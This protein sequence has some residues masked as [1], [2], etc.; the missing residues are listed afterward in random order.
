M[1]KMEEN[2]RF[3]GRVEIPFKKSEDE[4]WSALQTRLQE[5]KSPEI[6]P[7]KRNYSYWFAA[8][9][10][11]V[12]ALGLYMFNGMANEVNVV[13]ESAEIKAIVLPDGSE[14]T[15][16]ADGKIKYHE[17]WSVE[18]VVELEGQAFFNVKRGSRFIVHTKNGDVEVLGTSFDVYSRDSSFDVY[19]ETGKVK[20]TC[21]KNSEIITPGQSVELD[22]DL[23]RKT[24]VTSARSAWTSG[25]FVYENESLDEVLNEIERQFNIE[26]KRPNF[27]SV[28]YTGEF[29]NTNL[30]DAL[31]LVL[32][33][34][35][36]TFEK[37]SDRKIEVMPNNIE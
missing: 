32:S 16:N 36:M 19:C 23:L 4:A 10:A 18:R 14:V 15:L 20:V 24:T 3:W 35:N 30:I 12:V 28:Y 27:R 22:E 8:A 17:D 5:T 37:V 33:P 11:I 34:F 1:N 26:I 2:K 9:A 29:K 6:I 31:N 21:G 25:R 13:A 7:I